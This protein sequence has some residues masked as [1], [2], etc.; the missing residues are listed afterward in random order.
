MHLLSGSQKPVFAFFGPTNWRRNHDLGQKDY[1]LTRQ[2]NDV[3]G[4]QLQTPAFA[5]KNI[6]V[7]FVL[8]RLEKEGLLKN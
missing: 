6:S 4:K 1:V 7:E 2:P 8:N 5:L 3:V